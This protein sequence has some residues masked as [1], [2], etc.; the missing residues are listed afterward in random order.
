MVIE[1]FKVV[2]DVGL[3]DVP[4]DA[5][6]FSVRVA[7]NL[8]DEFKAH[9]LQSE[10]ANGEVAGL[11]C[12][13][14]NIRMTGRNQQL[15]PPLPITLRTER[16]PLLSREDKL[17]EVISQRLLL[18]PLPWILPL[19]FELPFELGA[20][21]FPHAAGEWQTAFSFRLR[22]LDDFDTR[23]RR[24]VVTRAVAGLHAD[25]HWPSRAWL[26]ARPVLDVQ[27]GKLL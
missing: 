7:D 11:L 8:P 15:V 5:R 10:C 6:D 18:R 2:L 9:A 4:V 16:L 3:L 25:A 27:S 19:P 24:C 1:R 26:A 13:A 14:I 23:C 20:E 12:R 22:A 17:R 21:K